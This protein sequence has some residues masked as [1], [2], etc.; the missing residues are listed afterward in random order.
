MY[1][2]NP[3]IDSDKVG[4]VLGDVDH[5]VSVGGGVGWLDFGVGVLEYLLPPT[6]TASSSWYKVQSPT[7]PP[8]RRRSTRHGR[9][10]NASDPITTIYERL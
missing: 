1:C 2:Q 7:Q 5:G 9:L 8:I 6:E 10:H 4:N 3:D